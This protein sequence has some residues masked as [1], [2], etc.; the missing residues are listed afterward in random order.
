MTSEK[1][2]AFLGQLS[3][4]ELAGAIVIAETILA[5]RGFASSNGISIRGNIEPARPH[6]ADEDRPP[7]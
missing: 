5:S 3:S 2:R 1:I 7:R 4:N 6:Y